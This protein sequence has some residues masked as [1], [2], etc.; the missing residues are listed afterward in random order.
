MHNIKFVIYIT[1]NKFTIRQNL[2]PKIATDEYNQTSMF[3]YLL[4]NY[5]LCSF[6]RGTNFEWL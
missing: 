2:K 6:L 4:V 1:F 3:I 5:E